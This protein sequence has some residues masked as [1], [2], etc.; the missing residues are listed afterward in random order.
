MK[1]KTFITMM[2]ISQK[3]FAEKIGYSEQC[4]SHW[5]KG[6]RKPSSQAMHKIK[7][8]TNGAVNADDFVEHILEVK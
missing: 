6:K 1:L 3:Q 2:Q 4:V 8:V 5:S 7:Q